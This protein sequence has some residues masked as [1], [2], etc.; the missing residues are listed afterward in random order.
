MIIL[1]TQK[2]IDKELPS[3]FIILNK[4][5]HYF[6]SKLVNEIIDIVGASYSLSP[7]EKFKLRIGSIGIH[8]ANK[9]NNF[10]DKINKSSRIVTKFCKC[11][12]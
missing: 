9:T 6:L 1:I 10:V 8:L 7:R 3:N 2:D 12:L 11:M 4:K 5:K